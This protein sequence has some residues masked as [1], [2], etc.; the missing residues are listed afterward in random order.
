MLTPFPKKLR[1]LLGSHRSYNFQ[2]AL[3]LKPQKSTYSLLGSFEANGHTEALLS[4][5]VYQGHH[6]LPHCSLPALQYIWYRSQVYVSHIW[7]HCSA[8]KKMMLVLHFPRKYAGTLTVSEMM[9]V[10]E[11]MNKAWQLTSGIY[12]ENQEGTRWIPFQSRAAGIVLVYLGYNLKPTAS[13][14]YSKSKGQKSQS[15]IASV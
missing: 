9:K 8:Q 7:E 5:P 14:L 2:I 12:W 1:N 4:H 6:A 10:V 15:C 13:H 3:T 11:Q